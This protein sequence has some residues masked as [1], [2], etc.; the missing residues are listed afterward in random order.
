VSESVL[1]SVQLSQSEQAWGSDRPLQQ[2]APRSVSAKQ[3]DLYS[4][5]VWLSEFDQEKASQRALASAQARL[6]GSAKCSVKV[7]F[8]PLS[9]RR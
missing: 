2:L 6:R 8:S 5:Q 1:P 3:P 9:A 4:L 7:R